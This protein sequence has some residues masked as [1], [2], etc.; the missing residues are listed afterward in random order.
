[1]E[2]KKDVALLKSILNILVR[3][4]NEIKID[5][6]V[7]EMGV[8]ISF[9]VASEDVGMVIGKEGKT[10]TA[11][12]HLITIIGY[13]IDSKVALKFLAPPKNPSSG[14]RRERPEKKGIDDLQL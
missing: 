7:D 4:P 14:D 12:R 13:Q 3:N 11:I 9:N 10:I 5:R 6:T 8:L 1:M 2:D